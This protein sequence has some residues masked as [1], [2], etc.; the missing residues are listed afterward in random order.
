[1]FYIKSLPMTGYKPRTSSNWRHLFCQLSHNHGPI[2]LWFVIFS[3]D[4]L[5]F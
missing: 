2:F 4:F 3:F 5:L 1:M